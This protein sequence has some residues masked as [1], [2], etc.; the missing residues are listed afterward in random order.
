MEELDQWTSANVIAPLIGIS[1]GVSA[2]EFEDTR[3]AVQKSI[4]GKVLESYRN[5]QQ[6][7]ARRFKSR[8]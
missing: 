7:A 6:A 5:G 4:R 8:R 3:H 2:D 1:K